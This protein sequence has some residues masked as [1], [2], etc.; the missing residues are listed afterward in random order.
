MNRRPVILRSCA[1]RGTG[2]PSIEIHAEF[3]PVDMTNARCNSGLSDHER[4]RRSRPGAQSADR[5]R[6]FALRRHHYV[7]HAPG[8]TSFVC[9]DYDAIAACGRRYPRSSGR[10]SIRRRHH[11]VGSFP[12]GA[13]SLAGRRRSAVRT[14]MPRERFGMPRRPGRHRRRMGSAALCRRGVVGTIDVELRRFSSG[15]TAELLSP[16]PPDVVAAV[17]SR[18]LQTPQITRRRILELIGNP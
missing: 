14:G 5:R 6:G 1:M 7:A 18:G 10:R 4:C 2:S 12:Y 9:I 15:R 3:F 13:S 11:C 16:L 17:A 8:R